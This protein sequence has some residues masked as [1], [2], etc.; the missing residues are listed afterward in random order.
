MAPGS[1]TSLK[2]LESNGRPALESYRILPVSLMMLYPYPGG[3]RIPETECIFEDRPIRKG[4]MLKL[5]SFLIRIEQAPTVLCFAT[6]ITYSPSSLDKLGWMDK[7][8]V[9]PG[10][11][12]ASL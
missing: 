4:F 8:S 10:I 7:E 5:E 11:S 1:S 3:M 6:V 2:K 9:M 12:R